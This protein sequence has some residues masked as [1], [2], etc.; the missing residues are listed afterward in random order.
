MSRG[1]LFGVS[2]VTFCLPPFT[3]R[4]IADHAAGTSDEPVNSLRL[5][6]RCYSPL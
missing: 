5:L 2:F 4:V 6:G 3:D 1:Q